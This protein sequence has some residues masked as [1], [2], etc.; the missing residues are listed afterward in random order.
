MTIAW[1]RTQTRDLLS[2]NIRLPDNVGFW[3]TAQGVGL[4]PVPD[5]NECNE[6]IGVNLA[7]TEGVRTDKSA[8][9]FFIFFSFFSN[10]ARSVMYLS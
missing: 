8:M 2:D 9:S 6:I 5:M 1:V 7:M 10:L 4:V 3:A